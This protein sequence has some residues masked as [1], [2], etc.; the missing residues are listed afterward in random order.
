[1]L[2]QLGLHFCSLGAKPRIALC[3]SNQPLTKATPLPLCHSE[4]S[5]GIVLSTSATA[6]QAVTA[7]RGNHEPQ[8][9]DLH[10]VSQ[11]PSFAQLQKRFIDWLGSW[12]MGDGSQRSVRMPLS[13]DPSPAARDSYGVLLLLGMRLP[14]E[15]VRFLGFARNDKG[16]R[17]CFGL[18][19]LSEGEG[20]WARI[21]LENGLFIRSFARND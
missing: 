20:S 12:K 6:F 19:L 3:L 13:A 10:L 5:R 18:N 15:R 14:N 8:A 17:S 21:L 9:R 1:M 7:L 11:R 2:I 4:R 16:R